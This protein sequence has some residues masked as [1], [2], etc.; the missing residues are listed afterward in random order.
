MAFCRKASEGA[1][2]VASIVA[3][4][5]FIPVVPTGSCEDCCSE[6]SREQRPIRELNFTLSRINIRARVVLNSEES[7]KSDE[8]KFC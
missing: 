4:R 7:K 6:I 1:L 5:A 2:A 3:S 8:R